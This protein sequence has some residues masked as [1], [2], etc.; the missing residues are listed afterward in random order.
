MH[1]PRIVAFVAQPLLKF[2]G[3]LTEKYWPTVPCPTCGNGNLKLAGSI[4]DVWAS[5]VVTAPTYPPLAEIEYSGVFKA[6]LRCDEG[7]CREGVVVSGKC[8]VDEQWERDDEDR[9]QTLYSVTF[10]Q[11]P[12]RL[13]DIPD[14]TPEAVK[15]ASQTPRRC[16]G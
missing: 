12:L 16:S 14:N 13:F 9:Y 10:V 2:T 5:H 1:S 15:P 3:H 4:D 8:L 11:P 7:S 6:E